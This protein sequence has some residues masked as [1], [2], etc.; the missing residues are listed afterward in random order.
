MSR[1]PKVVAGAALVAVCLCG[2][3]GIDA[4]QGR[5]A[6]SG[7]ARK[8]AVGPAP[9]VFEQVVGNKG[10]VDVQ[11]FDSWA[12]VYEY[13]TESHQLLGI[14]AKATVHKNTGTRTKPQLGETL[15]TANLESPAA[16]ERSNLDYP[17]RPKE[18]SVTETHL[19]QGKPVYEGRLIFQPIGEISRRTG[20]EATSGET[21]ADY[22]HS[23]PMYNYIIEG[24]QPR[25]SSRVWTIRLNPK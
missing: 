8:T 11:L 25:G 13:P 2:C 7:A 24:R 1:R 20:D 19:N 23:W 15:A 10:T 6:S 4:N 21:R 12:V 5:T 3:T 9:S 22:I 17:L 16:F 14:P 18:V